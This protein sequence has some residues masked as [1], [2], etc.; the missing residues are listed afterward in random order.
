MA[1]AGVAMPAGTRRSVLNG[2]LAGGLLLVLR[3]RIA[4]APGSRSESVQ[5]REDANFPRHAP[6]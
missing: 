1:G 2:G 5:A 4:A 6:I 3:R